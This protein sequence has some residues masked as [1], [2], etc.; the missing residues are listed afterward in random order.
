VVRNLVLGKGSTGLKV[1]GAQS[2]VGWGALERRLPARKI[3]AD[4]GVETTEKPVLRFCFEFEFEFYFYFNIYL[5]PFSSPSHFD[6][7]SFFPPMRSGTA[8]VHAHNES[9]LD[10]L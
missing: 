3:F 8:Y 2:G 6:F 4:P 9:P 5:F 10:R 1:L 7:Y